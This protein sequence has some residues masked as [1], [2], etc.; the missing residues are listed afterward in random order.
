MSATLSHIA[1]GSDLTFSDVTSN[2]I[3]TIT[4]INRGATTLLSEVESINYIAMASGFIYDS[5]KILLLPSIKIGEKNM[6]VPA[7]S[8]LTVGWAIG[9]TATLIVSALAIAGGTLAIL[10]T[11][12][13][14]AR[15]EIS[16]VRDGASDDN[17]A[18][19]DDMRH[20]F[21]ITNQKLDKMTSMLTDIKVDQ[22]NNKY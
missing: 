19:R 6:A 9:L 5:R 2:R 20:D 13:N 1:I 22:A 14:D 3:E 11:D 7:S 21:D 12:I 18:L 17:K 10:H 4:A 8:P 16:A 15:A